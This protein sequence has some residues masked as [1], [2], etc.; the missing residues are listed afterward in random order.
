MITIP[1]SWHGLQSRWLIGLCYLGLL[2]ACGGTGSPSATETETETEGGTTTS[3]GYHIVG[4]VSSV[5]VNASL[6][7]AQETATVTDVIAVSPGTGDVSCKSAT[8]DATAGTFDL[9]VAS[10][11][12]WIL[13]F[14]DAYRTQANMFLGHFRTSTLDTLTP[15]T[16]E[17]TA[18]LGSVTVNAESGVATS[19]TD[20]TEIIDDLG[21]D[22]ET[23]EVVGEVDDVATRY[24]NPDL[25][26]DG[27]VD[28]QTESGDEDATAAPQGQLD[29][30]VRFNMLINGT[31]SRVNNMIGRF[32]D[33]ATTTAQYESTGVYVNYLDSFS[34]AASGNVTCADSAVTTSEGGAL[35]ANTATTAVTENAFGNY[36]GFG[37]NIVNTSELP[38]GRIVFAMG[39]KT[40]TFT[41]VDTPSLAELTA[42][43]GRI[44]PF[45]SLT[46]TDASCT[47][48]CTV[49]SIEY[50][51]LKK[52]AG[53]WE[54]VTVA[55]LSLL[56]R[57]GTPLFGFRV[58]ENA[59]TTVGFAIPISQVSGTIAWSAE[60]ATLSGVTSTQLI[61]L[62]T[63]QICHVGLSY[64]D[65]LGMRY[66]E[67]IENA[68]GS[69]GDT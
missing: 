7:K 36:H 41:G 38:S 34:T 50:Q 40:L 3:S 44:F 32:F 60:N 47:T 16:T 20:H 42:P 66:F 55:E 31:Q 17:G 6:G 37:I 10:G 4:T 26:G 48:E 43:T 61:N 45:L 46:L 59:N 25:D 18:Q 54:E 35:A 52:T 53:G 39:T 64:D 23:A 62:V 8:V 14:I 19:T 28:C 24:S 51:W 13:F 1:S 33:T 12:P 68:V 27:T 67:T 69:C 21:V 11:R 56:I 63:T 22:S 2:C 9:K 57:A 5:T 58:D 29:F 30:H 49:S 15:T 65:Q